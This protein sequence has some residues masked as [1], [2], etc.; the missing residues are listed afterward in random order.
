MLFAKHLNSGLPRAS[1][2][3][4]EKN[5]SGPPASVG[6]LKIS[7]PNWKD[8]LSVAEQFGLALKESVCTINK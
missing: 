4:G 2:G 6:W 8:C 1:L 3:H 7:T 5:F